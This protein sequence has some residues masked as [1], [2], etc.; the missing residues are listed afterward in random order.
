M[1]KKLKIAVIGGGTGIFPV[2]SG[3]KKYPVEITAIVSMADDGGSTGI[4]REEFGI[5]PPGDVRRALVALSFEEEL[6]CKLFNYR[7]EKGSLKGHN[8]GNIFIT[9]LCKIF[10]DD[11]EKA[12]EA[13]GKILNIKGKVIPV[14]LG[15]AKLYA[16]LEDGSLI[17]GETNIDI[18]KHD[19]NLKLEKV[20]LKPSCKINPRAKKAIF[21]ADIL[22]IGPGDIYT[23]IIPNLLVKG[24]KEA[25]KK[26]KAKKVYILNL[27]TKFGETNGFCAIDFVNEVE[28]YLGEN[29]LDFVILNKK[30]PPE[31]ILK[32]YGKKKAFFVEYS[33][34]D[35]K[36]RPFKIIEADLLRRGEFL[37]HDP[38]K[39][40]KVIYSLK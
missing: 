26:S 20:F 2:L 30:R 31:K 16:R 1:K 4:L 37:R 25:I 21:E 24:V 40:A 11:F 36:D 3:L 29:V 18:P 13:T 32:K 15:K 10:N 28:K 5:L 38:Q 34:E 6:L 23:S 33:K 39:I 14:T 12:I 17:V 9:A 19:G 35:F 7:F 8:F 27:M 22:V